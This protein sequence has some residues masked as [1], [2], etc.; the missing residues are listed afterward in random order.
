MHKSLMRDH[1]IELVYDNYR[2]IKHTIIP[3]GFSAVALAGFGYDTIVW[4]LV[5][6]TC[7]S[8]AAYSILKWRNKTFDLTSERI[9][10]SEGVFSKRQNDIPIA[11]VSGIRIQDSI[12][13]RLVG[14]K[15]LQIEIIGGNQES[16]VLSAEQIHWI[17]LN[18]FSSIPAQETSPPSGSSFQFAHYLLLSL[19]KSIFLPALISSFTL[20]ELAFQ[21]FYRDGGDRRGVADI[22]NKYSSSWWPE[23]LPAIIDAAGIIVGVTI[24]LSVPASLAIAYLKYSKFSVKQKTNHLQ[25]VSGLFSRKIVNIPYSH[26][27]SVRICSSWLELRLGFVRVCADTVG[28]G[29]NSEGATV[30]LFPLIRAARLTDILNMYLP[31]FQFPEIRHRAKAGSLVYYLANRATI[32]SAACSMFL[33]IIFPWSALAWIIV[34]YFVFAGFMRHRYA[35]LTFEG[36]YMVLSQ[37]R[38]LMKET[39]IFHMQS[40]QSLMYSQ[41]YWQ[42]RGECATYTFSVYSEQLTE[43]YSCKHMD[44]RLKKDW[45]K[46]GDKNVTSDSNCETF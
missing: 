31:A 39:V 44:G 5:V 37:W 27:R 38:A 18:I 12:L 21:Y 8:S 1:V 45:L 30:E 42:R 13:K 11:N 14:V 32:I 24:F 23:S 22:L 3:M 19:R 6:L 17:Q 25:V 26:I 29:K 34:V 15:E 28:F 2:R 9:I 35:G 20:F 41:T 40:V 16:F 7:T 10:V 43:C 46:A 33:T 4:I 36:K